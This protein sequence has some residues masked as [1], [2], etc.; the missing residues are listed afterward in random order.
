MKT[1]N[2]KLSGDGSA[3][4]ENMRRAFGNRN[5]QIFFVLPQILLCSENFVL[6]IWWKQKHFPLKNVFCLPNP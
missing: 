1:P 3:Q 6:N 5:P 2:G 4:A